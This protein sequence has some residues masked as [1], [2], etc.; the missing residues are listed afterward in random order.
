MSDA[1]QIVLTLVVGFFT[2]VLSGMFGVGGAVIST[3]AIRV[4]GAT[5]FEAVGSTV[6]SILPSSITGTLRY[7][8]EGLINWRVVGWTGC[9]GILSTVAG[10]LLSHVVPGNGHV[11]MI[12]T[13]LLVGFTAFRLGRSP[14]RP[15]P[16]D[17]EEPDALDA[18]PPSAAGT[19]TITTASRSVG[20]RTEWWRLTIIGVSAGLLSGLLGVGGGILMVPLFVSWARLELKSALGTSLACVG[21]LAVPGI[22]THQLL[23]DIDWAFALP[24]CIGVIPGA[25][26]GA[27]LT[28]RSSD[29]ALRLS[30]AVVL[31]SIALIYLIGEIVSLA[32]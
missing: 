10:A 25:R 20:E 9:A 17:A 12:L 1:I 23:G 13:A 16:S 5:P 2:G 4:L 27:H 24:L 18:P 19:T 11:L 32:H 6:P 3:P 8:R 31:G 15:D 22:I 28:I 7:Q 14:E 29:R 26:V 30:V 21:I